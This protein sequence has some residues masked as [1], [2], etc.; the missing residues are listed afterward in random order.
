MS[1][2]QFLDMRTYARLHRAVLSGHGRWVRSVS[3][4]PLKA[5]RMRF[6]WGQSLQL[7]LRQGKRFLRFLAY[8]FAPDEVIINRILKSRT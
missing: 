6:K 5:H 8:S 3:E 1:S 7:G 4:Y 2:C